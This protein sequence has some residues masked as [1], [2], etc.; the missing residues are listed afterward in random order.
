[1]IKYA[2]SDSPSLG[3]IYKAIDGTTNGKMKFKGTPQEGT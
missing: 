3:K 1:M 2:H